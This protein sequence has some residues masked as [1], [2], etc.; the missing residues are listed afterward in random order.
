[1]HQSCGRCRHRFRLVH[2]DHRG[3]GTIQQHAGARRPVHSMSA[4]SICH[5]PDSPR[6]PGMPDRPLDP[7]PKAIRLPKS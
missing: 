3:Q 5:S 1:M 7:A 6:S 4:A 2:D